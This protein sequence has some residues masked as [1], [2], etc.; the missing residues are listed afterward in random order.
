MKVF[1]EARPVGWS[2]TGWGAFAFFPAPAKSL[3]RST[4]NLLCVISPGV[5]SEHAYTLGLKREGSLLNSSIPHVDRGSPFP[6][7]TEKRD[8]VHL[9]QVAQFSGGRG[10]PAPELPLPPSPAAWATLLPGLHS[11]LELSQVPQT[12]GRACIQTQPVPFLNST[13]PSGGHVPLRRPKGLVYDVLLRKGLQTG[14]GWE[15][16]GNSHSVL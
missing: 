12:R 3:L 7:P 9:C 1:S 6:A 2:G 14:L 5:P 10:S 8:L 13:L 4:A 16:C 15:K 11:L